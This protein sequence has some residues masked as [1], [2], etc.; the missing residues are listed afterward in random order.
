MAKKQAVLEESPE[1]VLEAHF[2]NLAADAVEQ[3]IEG[4]ESKQLDNLGDKCSLTE[5][6][7][8]GKLPKLRYND[9]LVFRCDGYTMVLQDGL[10][11]SGNDSWDTFPYINEYIKD[12][13]KVI[14][15]GVVAPD[16]APRK[17][18][19]KNTKFMLV[20][21]GDEDYNELV[22]EIDGHP[23]ISF[24]CVARLVFPGI[25]DDAGDNTKK[26]NHARS[27]I[28]QYLVSGR[29]K[30]V[31]W[32]PDEHRKLTSKQ[33]KQVT[34]YKR[35]ESKI[36]KNGK[37]ITLPTPPLGFTLFDSE[38]HRS[39]TVLI[40]DTES[41]KTYLIGQDEGTYFGVELP[42]NPETVDDA[43]S[44][45]T[46]P[47]AKGVSGVLRQGEWFAIPVSKDEV[48]T[49]STCVIILAGGTLPKDD[50]ESNDHEL[51]VEE[52]YVGINGKVYVRGGYIRHPEHLP[53]ELDCE[54]WY[55]FY[56]NTAVRSVS[57]QGVD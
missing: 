21:N 36:D 35:S 5:Y 17:G 2:H 29:L 16:T 18:K 28:G 52:G 54:R 23:T 14:P 1:A 47:E 32:I 45:L 42:S 34:R 26:L 43:Y 3:V 57:V 51:D 25:T 37:P 50:V 8:N 12:I 27:K 55:T 10:I 33:R 46:P 44:V 22:S 49:E 11:F 30:I 41:Q 24:D 19:T 7:K 48:P 40:F 38:F 20:L 4:M 39:A 31:D 6:V 15:L 53:L 9:A 13:N 56:R